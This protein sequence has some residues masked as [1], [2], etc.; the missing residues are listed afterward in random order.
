MEKIKKAKVMEKTSPEKKC[1]P[2]RV[3]RRRFLSSAAMGMLGYSLMVD[4]DADAASVG[5]RAKNAFAKAD[6][7]GSTTA[8]ES[9]ANPFGQSTMDDVS[10]SC[11]VLVAGGGLSGICAALAAARS[12]AK[13]V[14]VQNRSNLGG[15]SS[16]EVR[17]HPLGISSWKVGFREGGILEEL[18][19]KNAAENSEMS[20]AVW[21]MVLYDKVRSEKNITLL[22]DTTL[23][24]AEVKNG[25]IA[26]AFAR[27][28]LSLTNYV[29]SAKQFIDCTGDCRLAL[30]AGAEV[31][32]GRDGKEKYDET[33]ADFFTKG[34]RLC[35]SIL[36]TSR[37]AGREVKFTPP[38]W[39]RKVTAENMKF[40]DPKSGGG[41]NYGYWFISFG[42]KLDTVRD[43][44]VIRRELLA[45][46]LGVWGYIKNCGKYPEAK[47]LD[48]DFIGML[49]AR[50]DTYRIAGFDIFTQHDIEGGW[51]NRPDQII[52]VGWP[53]EDQPSDGFDF[54]G[55]PAI[56][57]GKTPYYNLPLTAMY[58]KDVKNLMMAGRNMNTSHIAFTS[59]R[60]M[61]TGALAGEVAGNVAA[62]CAARGMNPRE[63]GLSEKTLSE[64]RQKLI[65]D[66]NII[67]GFKNED[68]ADLILRASASA[69]ASDFGTSPDNAKNGVN[70]DFI[71]ENKNR[72]QAAIDKS[73]VLAF[74]WE[75]PV[76]ISQ[77]RLNLDTGCRQLTQSCEVN[78]R[79][80]MI[81]A[82][83]PETLRDFDITAVLA[84]GKKRTLARV[85]GN[86]QKMV[87]VDFGKV[88]V[89]SVSVKCLA[90]NGDEKASIF[91]VRAYA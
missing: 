30:E 32:A 45:I 11:D 43:M 8:A 44:E 2:K 66:G 64:L 19:L 39:A 46:L 13:V 82:P 51:R 36:F 68:P 72:W 75:K 17:M 84:D 41:L 89:K 27:C 48:L 63:A 3:S 22:L 16:S 1:S 74:A 83:Q 80:R 58:S 7:R 25:L 61:N 55:K 85:R 35:C 57:G 53:M 6:K 10:L 28:D 81:L 50:R 18:K 9:G 78:F 87:R 24:G 60:I 31:M 62:L 5:S 52:T 77:V 59:T 14:L 67:V 71:G 34:D 26:R 65:K 91:E 88:A 15:N 56:Y 4:V 23:F 86:C 12:G 54:K 47:N 90:T 33:L 21:E 42:G 49:P 70:F 69:T 37:D 40:R 38:A 20:W 76:E 29:I 73:P 79:S